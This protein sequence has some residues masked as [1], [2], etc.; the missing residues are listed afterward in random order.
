MT[1]M[2][3]SVDM[4]LVPGPITLLHDICSS[5]HAK[6]NNVIWRVDSEDEELKLFNSN[7]TG[8]ILGTKVENGRLV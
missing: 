2:S 6:L 4:R 1:Y 8:D 3:P 5:F 7:Q